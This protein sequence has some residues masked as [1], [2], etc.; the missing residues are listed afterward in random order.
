[1]ARRDRRVAAGRRG[2][3]EE[4]ET[5]GGMDGSR[6]RARARRNRARA[7]SWLVDASAG[8]FFVFRTHSSVRTER[9]LTSGER[10]MSVFIISGCTYSVNARCNTTTM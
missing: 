1:M 5:A 2:E 8:V 4:E 7:R 10:T 3:E 6:R 9:P